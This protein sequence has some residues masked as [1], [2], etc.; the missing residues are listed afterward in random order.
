[1]TRPC[2]ICGVSEFPDGFVENDGLDFHDVLLLL[3][4]GVTLTRA[5]WDTLGVATSFNRVFMQDGKLTY[6]TWDGV[7]DEYRPNQEDLFASDWR[8]I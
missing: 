6:C 3:E 4:D 5:A 2:P 7:Q 8:V 1:M